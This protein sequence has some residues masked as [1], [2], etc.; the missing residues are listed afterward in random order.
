M[1]EQSRTKEGTRHCI[2]ILPCFKRIQSQNYDM[3]LLVECNILFLYHAVMWDNCNTAHS[4]HHPLCGNNCLGLSDIKR[5]ECTRINCSKPLQNALFSNAKCLMHVLARVW[6]ATSQ[7]K[8][9]KSINK[10]QN[11]QLTET[12]IVDSD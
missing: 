7:N 12:K 4:F 1:V 9:A 8:D 10:I 11:M 6:I 2:H 3:E 5:P